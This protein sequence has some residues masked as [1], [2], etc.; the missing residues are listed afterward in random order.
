MEKPYVQATGEA[1]VSARPDQALMRK[2]WPPDW[3]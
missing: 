3:D 1:T 2:E